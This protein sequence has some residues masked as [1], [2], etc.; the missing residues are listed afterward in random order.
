[1]DDVQAAIDDG[2][3]R[4]RHWLDV[5]GMVGGS[6]GAKKDLAQDLASF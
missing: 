2:T 6:D 4:E 1:M 3:L 5:K